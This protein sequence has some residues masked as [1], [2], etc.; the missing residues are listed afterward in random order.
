MCVCVSKRISTEAKDSV[1]FPG[2]GVM[3]VFMP[4]VS[5]RSWMLNTGLLEEQQEVFTAESP[6]SAPIY[7]MFPFL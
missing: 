4:N 1:R 2:A 3:V 6:P 5:A 7:C